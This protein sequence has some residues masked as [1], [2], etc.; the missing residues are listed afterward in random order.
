MYVVFFYKFKNI[1][2]KNSIND[3]AIFKSYTLFLEK[4]ICIIYNE[5]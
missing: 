2:L 3:E 1:L 5:K 4:K